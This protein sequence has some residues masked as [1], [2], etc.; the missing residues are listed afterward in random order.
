MTELYTPEERSQRLVGVDAVSQELKQFKKLQHLSNE[1]VAFRMAESVNTIKRLRKSFHQTGY[2]L[3]EIGIDYAV[4][5]ILG[6]N[7][8]ATIDQLFDASDRKLLAIPLIG[9]ARVAHIREKVR[10]FLS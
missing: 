6:A 1:D 5:V 7:G 10:E 3:S 4:R 9:P 8:I 2:S